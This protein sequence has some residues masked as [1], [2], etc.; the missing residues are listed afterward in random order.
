[1]SKING[2]RSWPVADIRLTA[3]TPA[4]PTIT[5]EAQKRELAKWVFIVIHRRPK[6]LQPSPAR[7]FSTAFKT[8]GG[9]KGRELMVT[10]MAFSTALATA[11]GAETIGGS[12]TPRTP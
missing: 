3:K 2:V 4:S 11:A 1:M 5:T 8:F 10:P 7:A 6:R 12:P 9:D